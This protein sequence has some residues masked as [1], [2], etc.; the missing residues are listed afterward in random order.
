MP[1][2][3]QAKLMMEQGQTFTSMVELTDSGD[4]IT[5]N[6]AGTLWSRADGKEP[7]VAVN[8]LKSGGVVTATV[9]NDQVSAA[10]SVV[11]LNGTADTSVSADA[12]LAV[13]R[14]SVNAFI[15]NSITVTSAGIYA[16]VAGTE[17]TAF[18]E[19]RGAAGGPPYI[20]VDSIEVAQVR[21]T[22][23]SAAPV[24]AAEIFQVIGVHLEKADYPLYSIDYENGDVIFTDALSA[25]HTGDVP[26][27]V[28]AEYY[29]G[30]LVELTRASDFSMPETTHSTSSEQVYNETIASSSSS[31]GQGSFTQRIEDGATDPVVAWKNQFLWFK[32]FPNRNK[33]AYV[34]TQGKLGITRSW[35]AGDAISADCTISAESAGTEF[36]S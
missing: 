5:F 29:G 31:L 13:T 12:A 33:T 8:G 26:K 25:V 2:A 23:L 7:T 27:K 24:T 3:S 14:G 17:S 34:L 32:F 36:A 4:A 20:P 15:I 22:S 30:T 19:T 18:T 35:P 9:T 28:F 16:V 1:D 6:S 21:L 11:N 10:A